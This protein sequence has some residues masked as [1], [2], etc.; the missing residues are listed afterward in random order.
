MRQPTSLTCPIAKSFWTRN[1]PRLIK[2]GTLNDHTFDAFVS[3]CQVA[4]K[5]DTAEGMAWV[6]VNK[7]YQL[8]LEKFFMTPASRKRAKLDEGNDNI[9]TALKKLMGNDND[10]Q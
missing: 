9:G 6:C 2:D 4:S 8:G 7:Q 10:K 1:A 3:L 5:L